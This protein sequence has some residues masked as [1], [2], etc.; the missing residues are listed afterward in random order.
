MTGCDERQLADAER[1]LRAR[2]PDALRAIYRA[3]D[4]RFDHA[5]Q[6]WVVWPLERVIDNTL[7]AWGDGSLDRTLIAFGDDGTGDPFCVHNAAESPVIRWSIVGSE[8]QE[9]LSF[10]KFVAD[11]LND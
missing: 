1:R 6:W 9:V 8:V 4:G 5:G 3:A 7:R 2:L 10:N 11:W